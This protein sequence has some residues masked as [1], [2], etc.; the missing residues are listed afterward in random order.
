MARD[1]KIN[2]ITFKMFEEKFAKEG[3]GRLNPA[4]IHFGNSTGIN[5]LAGKDLAVIGTPYKV[6]EYYKLIA[7]Y[8]GGDVNREGDKRMSLRR[9]KY[10]GRSFLITAY[11]N[12]VLQEVQLYSIESEL[13]QCIGRARLLRNDCSVFVFSCFPCEQ[14]EIHI[15]NYLLEEEAGAGGRP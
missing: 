11:K 8:L 6:E 14:A 3:K 5:L 15:T 13:E 12:P 1:P 10:K 4:G 7:R 9:V 2:I